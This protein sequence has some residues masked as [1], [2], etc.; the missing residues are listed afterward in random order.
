MRDL[1]MRSFF[2]YKLGFSV[3]RKVDNLASRIDVGTLFSLDI[4]FHTYGLTSFS[5][6]F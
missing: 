5:V 4:Q 6:C 1:Y 2:L 3:I